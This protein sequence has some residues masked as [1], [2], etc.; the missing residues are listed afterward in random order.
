MKKQIIISVFILIQSTFFSQISF[1]KTFSDGGYD[2]GEGVVQ[3]ADSS[4]LITG[5]SSSFQD[6]NQAFILK[7][8]SLG[9]KIWSNHYGGSESDRGRRI[10]HVPNDGIYVVGQTN[11]FG[12]F[13]DAY[14]FKTDENGEFLY[15]KNYGSSAYENIHDAV[16]LSD[17][18]FILVGETTQTSNETENIYILRI[19]K[20]GDTLWTKNFGSNQKDVARAIELIDNS[21]ILIAGE[22][23]VQDS[24]TSKGMLLKMDIDGTIE[25]LKTYGE[26][27][28]YVFNDVHVYE[29]EIRAVGKNKYDLS[30]EENIYQCMFKFDIDGNVNTAISEIH[31]GIL[32]FE[33]L[34]KYGL[35]NSYYFISKAENSEDINTYEEGSDIIVL[36]FHKALYYEFVSFYCANT[37]QDTPNNAIATSDGGMILVGENNYIK[38]TASNIL[39]VKIGPNDFFEYS[40][41]LPSMETFVNIVELNDASILSNFYPNPFENEIFIDTEYESIKN[42][43]IFSVDGKIVYNSSSISNKISLDFL[44]PGVYNL[45]YQIGERNYN[46]K[47]LKN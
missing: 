12:N 1:Y 26:K 32:S 4:Y 40:N 28:E 23:F 39:V 5:S 45:T 18:S 37:G 11:S 35:G 21:T 22:Y 44:K 19:N 13:F 46:T 36:K 27:G 41:T 31:D 10:F 2:V 30:N 6:N 25:W 8:D 34:V 9:N 47:L 17:T 15:E 3:L 33:A 38:N 42:I 20:F 43:K 24:L 7:L 16:M 29:N 14:F